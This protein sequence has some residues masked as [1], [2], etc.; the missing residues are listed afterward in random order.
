MA[1]RK[2][3]QDDGSHSACETARK[4]QRFMCDAVNHNQRAGCPNP[5]CWIHRPGAPDPEPKARAA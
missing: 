4:Q 5:E 3:G 2:I 1:Y